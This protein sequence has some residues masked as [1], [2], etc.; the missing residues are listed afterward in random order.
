MTRRFFVKLLAG[1]Y[2]LIFGRSSQSVIVS[3]T[4]V[5][6][7]VVSRGIPRRIHK[8]Q[9]PAFDSAAMFSIPT[10]ESRGVILWS[11]GL[12]N[13]KPRRI[14]MTLVH[15]IRLVLGHGVMVL[16]SSQK[17]EIEHPNLVWATTNEN[18]SKITCEEC[19]RR[20]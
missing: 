17:V 13:H 1:V 19:K 4:S 10:S 11:N 6:H 12:I 2:G 14:D 16:C 15:G 8:I 7:S 3:E 18:N 5:N 9:R 20:L